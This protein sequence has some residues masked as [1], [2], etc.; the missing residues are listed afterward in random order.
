MKKIMLMATLAYGAMMSAQITVNKQGGGQINDGDTYTTSSIAAATQYEGNKLNFTVVN[1][2][3][4]TL[5]TAVRVNSIT[6][7]AN[8]D[9]LQ[10]CYNICLY[11]IAAGTLVPQYPSE[12]PLDPGASSQGD[13]HFF[14]QNPGTIAGEDVV[15]NLSFVITDA[16]NTVTSAPITFT[17]IYSPTAA[18]T[19]VNGLKNMGLN[20]NNTLVNSTL[21]IDATVTGVVQIFDINGKL[22]KSANITTGRQ[23]IDVAGFTNGVYF[24]RFTAGGKK[25]DIKIVKN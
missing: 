10:L 22:L 24:A 8:G 18:V 2:T 19:D 16:N 11:S 20:L 13:N 14:N 7:N 21:D 9:N 12:Y 1:N 3:E 23:S 4:E 25:A 6:N 5:Y 17:Y 15:Y